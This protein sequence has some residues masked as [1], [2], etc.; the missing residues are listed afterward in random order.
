MK[1]NLYVTTKSLIVV[2]KITIK[3]HDTITLINNELINRMTIKLIQRIQ[4]YVTNN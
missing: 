4:K 1:S 3:N 2:L